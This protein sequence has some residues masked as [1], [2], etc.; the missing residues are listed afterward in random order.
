MLNSDIVS[1]DDE[2]AP[3]DESDN[4]TMNSVAAGNPNIVSDSEDPSCVCE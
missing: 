4:S 1:A 3:E 2:I